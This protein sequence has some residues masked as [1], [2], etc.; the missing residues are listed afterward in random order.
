MDKDIIK[1]LDI[2]DE[3]NA[4]ASFLKNS[5][6][7]NV[8]S[9]YSTGSYVLDAIISG[10]LTGEKAGVP[11]GRITMFYGESQCFK[12]SLVLKV[13][14][15]AQK[16]GLTPIIF[17]TENAIDS[18]T[19]AGFGLDTSKVKYIVPKS[20]ESCK[21]SIYKFCKM[22]ADTNKKGKFIIAIDSLANLDSELEVS[23]MEK[24]SVSADMG[25]RAKAIKALLRTA[26]NMAAI[27]K[28]P[29]L[30][31]NHL[32]LNPSEMHPTLIKTPS[33][34]LA[35]VYMPSVSVQLMRKP[36]KEDA[37]KTDIGSTA[38]GQRN[39]SG[40][41]IRAI[42]AK[43]RF[44]KQYLEQEILVSFEKGVDKY[45]GLLELAVGFNIIQATGPTYSFNGEKLGYAKSFIDNSE[46]WENKIIPLL[47]EK[48][49]THWKYS[50][51]QHQENAKIESELG[52][53]VDENE[54]AVK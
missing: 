37:V 33:G 54:S 47:Q 52:L 25:S 21:N 31:T 4:Y 16:R 44:I 36:I 45:H 35:T 48:I 11:S 14:A 49:D 17:D 26:S 6:L 18:D 19:A 2:L 23:R 13:L 27:A 7:S 34:G 5:D 10:K 46:F 15:N 1:L 50:T 20:I 29:I 28:I 8:D 38:I 40:I 43:N 41:I 12:S 3:G 9:W 53:D 51:Q 30:I 24:D 39:Y 42:T 32:Y 22:A